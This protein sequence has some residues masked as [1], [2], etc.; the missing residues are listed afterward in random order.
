MVRGLLVAEL[1][2]PRMVMW[3]KF[4]NPDVQTQDAGGFGGFPVTWWWNAGKAGRVRQVLKP[5][6]YMKACSTDN[7]PRRRINV[8]R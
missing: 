2:G 3:D 4:D 6:R 1:D 5:R 8:G 7:S